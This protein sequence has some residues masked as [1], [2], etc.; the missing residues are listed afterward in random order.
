MTVII[1]EDD[2]WEA[3]APTSDTRHLA[4]MG[5]G[6]RA[7][8]DSVAAVFPKEQVLLW[9]R[10]ELAEVSEKELGRP[11]NAKAEPGSIFVNARARPDM[12]PKEKL[13][14]KKKLAV[15][16]E[17]VVVAACLDSSA[18]PGIMTRRG[19]VA[20]AKSVETLELP[21]RAF[22]RG[23]WDMVG[24]NGLAIA[25]QAGS[26]DVAA[27]ISKDVT[28]KGSAA[29]LRA[30]ESAQIEDH[31][32]LDLS[33]G[34][35]IF[36]EGT[37]VEAFSRISGPCFVGRNTKIRSALVRGGTSIFE[38]CRIGGEV[39]N[40]IIMSFSN[41]SHFGYVGDSI[42]G[43]WVN[44][45]AGATF[46]NLKNTYGY[47][48]VQVGGKKVETGKV[49]LGPAVG[50]MAK[51]SIGSLVYSGKK[52]GTGSQVGGT[53]QKDVP[54][55]SYLDGQSGKKRE[56][57]LES[58]LETQR[59]MMERRGKTLSKARE[60]LVRRLHTATAAQRLREGYR[61]GAI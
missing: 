47:V 50:D 49:M 4:Q 22:F 40:S 60:S 55:F 46:S 10:A 58:V 3:F 54:S 1:F 19:A 32:V 29:K 61:K 12:L 37:A 57:D 5:W 23:Y 53:V 43:E 13:T 9:G 36:E 15:V 30:E 24:S 45:G 11:Y 25:E 14:A 21:E 31:V 38:N 51:L 48:R 33:A 6:T 34:P 26:G 59:R 42:V 17:G 44:I 28:I 35:I 7:L 56:L 27:S 20:L 39:E 52:V 41:K 2:S 16:S 18:K 8:M